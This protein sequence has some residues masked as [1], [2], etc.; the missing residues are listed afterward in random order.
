MAVLHADFQCTSEELYKGE[1]DPTVK[2]KQ[3]DS[4]KHIDRNDLSQLD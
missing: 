4:A 3:P 1:A 2:C